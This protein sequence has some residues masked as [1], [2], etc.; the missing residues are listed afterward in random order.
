M[1]QNSS[2]SMNSAVAT[3]IARA[4]NR[5][6]A[7]TAISIRQLA[8][9]TAMNSARAP[10]PYPASF[11]HSSAP[12]V[13]GTVISSAQPG[14]G[15][16]KMQASSN[17]KTTATVSKRC[18]SMRRGA[19]AEVCAAAGSSLFPNG[20]TRG[21]GRRRLR[22][23]L[24]AGAAE[25]AFPAAVGVNGA[26]QCL[27]VEIRPQLVG[28][29]ELGIGQLPQ[30]EVADA[31]LAAGTDEQ[32]GLGRVAH[33]QV[34]GKM[35]LAVR[36]LRIRQFPHHAVDRL[37]D[38]PASAVIGGNGEREPVVAGGQLLRV[39]DQSGQTRLEAGQVAH[40]PETDAVGVE[41]A[42]L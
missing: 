26:S 11:A 35:G 31:L 28:E 34:R 6:A 1:A 12:S 23:E 20:P 17:G 2:A 29:V 10:R 30:Q 9:T 21:S 38:V 13:V 19:A 22:A 3:F 25:P 42:H 15:S 27:S 24:F 16:R 14:L 32:I 7:A 4:S 18:L 33:R 8:S 39:A 40:H 41:L 5:G 37:Q 36:I